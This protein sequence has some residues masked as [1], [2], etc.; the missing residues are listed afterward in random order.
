MKVETPDDLMVTVTVMGETLRVFFRRGYGSMVWTNMAGGG[1]D[2]LK[3]E[4]PL[5]EHVRV[6]Q[7]GL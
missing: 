6:M 5:A 7:H 3:Q 1:Q 2:Q 4:V